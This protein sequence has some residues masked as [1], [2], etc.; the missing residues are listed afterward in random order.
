[1]QFFYNPYT[2]YENLG[3]ALIAKN[4]LTIL[5]EKGSIKLNTSSVPTNFL[6]II[7]NDKCE[8]IPSSFSFLLAP[9][10]LR[11]KGKQAGFVFKPGHLY[12]GSAGI[13]GAKGFA[14]KMF[15]VFLLNLFGVKIYKTGVSIGPFDGLYLKYEKYVSKVSTFYGVRDDYSLEYAKQ[16]NFKNFQRIADLGY[17]HEQT[18]IPKSNIEQGYRSLCFTFRSFS[19]LSLSEQEQADKLALIIKQVFDDKPEITSVNCVT[20][21]QRDYDFNTLIINAL[22]K[23][24]VNVNSNYKYDITLDSYNKIANI[25]SSCDLMLSNRLHALIYASDYGATPVAIGDPVENFKVKYVLDDFQ[26]DSCFLDVNNSV[27]MFKGVIDKSINKKTILN[28][29]YNFMNI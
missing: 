3:D 17:F 21:V 26:G 13:G 27:D 18:N 6:D 28:K 14:F 23:L 1:M 10:L 5:S 9:F 12:G 25:Y 19:S 16:N 2:Q 15:Y 7:K 11:L 8:S 4:L 22:N 29:P 20:Q 24:G